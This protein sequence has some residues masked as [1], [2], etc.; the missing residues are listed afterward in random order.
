MGP[1]YGINY[2]RQHQLSFN[3]DDSMVK[4]L[5]DVQTYL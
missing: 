3:N 1:I 5:K 2:Q 4:P